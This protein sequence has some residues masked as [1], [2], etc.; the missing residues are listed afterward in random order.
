MGK[1]DNQGKNLDA[2]VSLMGEALSILAEKHKDMEHPWPDPKYVEKLK[3]ET[4]EGKIPLIVEEGSELSQRG[5]FKTMGQHEVRSVG[6]VKVSESIRVP[7]DLFKS[8]GSINENMGAILVHEYSH[9]LQ[10]VAAEG[11][12]ND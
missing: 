7:S 5:G 4:A 9:A 8:D 11:G 3:R 10:S 2:F 12:E 1:D 6:G